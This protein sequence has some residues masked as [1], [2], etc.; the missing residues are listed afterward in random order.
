VHSRIFF[1]SAEI[2]GDF[3]E[4][5]QKSKLSKSGACMTHPQSANLSSNISIDLT[6]KTVA[7]SQ[8]E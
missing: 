6:S 3:E 5:R 8:A 2:L 7:S 1:V 4:S